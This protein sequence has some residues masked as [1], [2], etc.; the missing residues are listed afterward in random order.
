VPHLAAGELTI[1]VG[2]KGEGG[3][4]GIFMKSLKFPGAQML[5]DSILLCVLWMKLVKS[6]KNYRKIQK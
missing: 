1:T 4:E 6:I 5:K 3:T 2:T